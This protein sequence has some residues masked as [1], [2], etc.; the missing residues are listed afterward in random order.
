M[1]LT[2]D[3]INELVFELYQEG[4]SPEDILYEL[5][6]AYGTLFQ[7]HKDAD[8]SEEFETTA[9]NYLYDTFDLIG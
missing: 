2:D 3:R 5:T 1:S 7:V 6:I 4:E 8:S 9:F